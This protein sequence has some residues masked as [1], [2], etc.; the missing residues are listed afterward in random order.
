MHSGR[1]HGERVLGNAS[2]KANWR[3]RHDVVFAPARCDHFIQPPHIRCNHAFGDTRKAFV[4]AP[5]ALVSKQ[6]LR[7]I[8]RAQGHEAQPSS[9]HP[10]RELFVRNHGCGVP[11]PHQAPSQAND[12]DYIAGAAQR[13]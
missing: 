3:R 9:L 2:T 4:C 11:A 7:L 12:R 13:R 10:F 5:K 8:A 6:L 1:R